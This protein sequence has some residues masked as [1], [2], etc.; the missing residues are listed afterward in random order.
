M[1]QDEAYEKIDKIHKILTGNGEVGLCEQTR[2]NTSEIKYL[3]TKI[4]QMPLSWR[5]WL[6]FALTILT[7]LVLLYV[8]YK[9]VV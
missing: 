6:T 8:T 9:K 4:K 1:T 7:F 5:S 2:N 3:K